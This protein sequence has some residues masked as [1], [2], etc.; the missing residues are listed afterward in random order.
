VRIIALDTSTAITSCALVDLPAPDGS[1][2][3]EAI[4]WEKELAEKA[5]DVLPLALGDL[6]GIEAVAVGLGPGSFTGLRVGLA[7]AKALSYARKLPV[8]GASSLQAL[9][10]GQAGLV[11]AAIDARRGELFTQLFRDGTPAGE[12]RVVLAAD[13]RLEGARLVRG[14]P[15]AAAVARLCRGSLLQP[16]DEE[17]CFALA[18]DYRQG[19][20]NLT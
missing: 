10:F 15:S 12:V 9:A 19:F 5:G 16:Y 7:A 8:A 11:C 13:L 14:T 18:P 4:V 3:G 1:G 2:D 17:S 6:D 20:A